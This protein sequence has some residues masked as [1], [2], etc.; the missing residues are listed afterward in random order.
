MKIYQVSFIDNEE[1]CTYKLFATKKEAEEFI[2]TDWSS[3]YGDIVSD[4]PDLLKLSSTSKVD[5]INFIN[6]L[7][8]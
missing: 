3:E 8:Y 2:N 4:K 6:H 1:N 5:I 7:T